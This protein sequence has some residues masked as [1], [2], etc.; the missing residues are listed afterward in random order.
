MFRSS[1]VVSSSYRRVT[2]P[3]R[4]SYFTNGQNTHKDDP[5]KILGLEWGD[6]ATSAEIKA[7]FRKQAQTLHPDIN[8]TD[9]PKDALEKFQR[10]QH[11]YESLMKNVAGMNGDN[12]DLE[13][14]RFALWRQ[15]DR[16]ALDRTDVAGVK[17]K[18]PVPP[19][20]ASKSYARELGHPSGKGVATQGEYI[21]YS[22]K[23]ASS[24]GTGRS[25][26]VKTKEFKPWAPSENNI[27]EGQ[28]K[29]N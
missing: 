15:S 22:T 7:A 27:A 26:W 28:T 23:R 29:N 6:G 19:A 11:A 18:R 16:L 5:F 17:R 21:G 20:S 25:K 14:W 3:V 8:R 13:Q 1:G 4:R 2:I 12:L 10:L 24:V 9:N